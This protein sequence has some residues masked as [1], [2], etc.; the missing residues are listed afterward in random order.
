MNITFMVFVLFYEMV[1]LLVFRFQL[2][3]FSLQ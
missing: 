2:Q 3:D 1:Y